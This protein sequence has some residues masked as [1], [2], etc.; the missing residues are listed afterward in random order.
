MRKVCL[1]AHVSLDGYLGGENGEMDWI[2]HDDEIFQYVTDHFQS[3]DTCLYGRVVYQMMEG[4]WPTVAKNPNATKLELQHANWVESIQ[5]IVFSTTLEK[6]EWKNTRL[7]KTE[8]AEEISKLKNQSGKK[9]MIFGSPRLTHSFLEIG[10][11]DEFLININPVI[12]GK[13]LPLFKNIQERMNLELLNIRIFKSDVVG[14]H[15]AKKNKE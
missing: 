14:L 9:M 3:V 1:L 13:G 4:Y 5:K 12:L 15:F 8:V 11:I 7:I 6:V 10:C 2:T